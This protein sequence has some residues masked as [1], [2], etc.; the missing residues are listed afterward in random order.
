MVLDDRDKEFVGL[1]ERDARFHFVLM[2]IAHNMV[3]SMIE[4][5]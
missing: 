2:V 4:A 1:A 3:Y 5:S